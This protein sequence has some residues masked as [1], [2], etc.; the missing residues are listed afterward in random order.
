MELGG[1]RAALHESCPV[2]TLRPS[3]YEREEELPV[4]WFYGLDCHYKFDSKCRR[5]SGMMCS[6]SGQFGSAAGGSKGVGLSF[7]QPEVAE[8]PHSQI[9]RINKKMLVWEASPSPMPHPVMPTLSLS[10][11]GF[12]RAFGGCESCTSSSCAS[13]QH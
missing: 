10:S 13:M 1:S 2:E 6:R 9:S 12:V 5:V 4:T 8:T 11:G 7:I 3:S